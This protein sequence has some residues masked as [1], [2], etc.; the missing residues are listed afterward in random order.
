MYTDP[1]TI[2]S[3]N[4]LCKFLNKTLVSLFRCN[5]QTLKFYAVVHR[6]FPMLILE[7]KD[8]SH[9]WARKYAD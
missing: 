8:I 5:L 7:K 6:T 9:F 1:N 4:F 3:R 2:N